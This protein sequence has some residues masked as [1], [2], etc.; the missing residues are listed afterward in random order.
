MRD[1]QWCLV[2]ETWWLGS[3]GMTDRPHKK[4][5][6]KCLCFWS[7][8][9][10]HPWTVTGKI[11]RALRNGPD[12]GLT[13][14][15]TLVN[16]A[17]NG[18]QNSLGDLGDRKTIVIRAAIGIGFGEW[19]VWCVVLHSYTKSPGRASGNLFISEIGALLEKIVLNCFEL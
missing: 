14:A 18:L 11:D 6:V 8:L 10:V 3:S 12:P 1:G 5:G 15:I 7:P 13:S 9:T 4:K 2:P 19:L 17:K 16:L